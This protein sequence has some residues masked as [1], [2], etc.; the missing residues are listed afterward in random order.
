[1]WSIRGAVCLKRAALEAAIEG[2]FP[3]RGTRAICYCNDGGASVLAADALRSMGYRHAGY[4]I[5]GLRQWIQEGLPVIRR[6][7]FDD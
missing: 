6:E 1:L 7:R 4:L 5:G 3:D 2:H